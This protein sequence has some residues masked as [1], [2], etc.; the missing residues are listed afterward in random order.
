MWADVASQHRFEDVKQ[1]AREM[2]EFNGEVI[3]DEDIRA[4]MAEADQ[5]E[6]DGFGGGDG[7]VDEEEF[8]TVCRK[9]GLL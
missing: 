6:G 8:V 7:E 5:G 3:T 4:M 2:L 1:V 9:A